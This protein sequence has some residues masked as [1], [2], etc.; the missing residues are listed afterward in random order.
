MWFGG[1]G[2]VAG[3]FPLDAGSR[4]DDLRC[5]KTNLLGIDRRHGGAWDLP[6]CAAALTMMI[7]ATTVVGL[8]IAPRW[9]TTPVALL[10]IAPVLA[11]AIRF[12]F[13]P[14]LVAAVASPLVYN[15]YFTEPYH[16]FLIHSPADIVSVAMLF[17]VALVVSRLAGSAREQAR[18]AQAHAARNATIAGFARQL[19]SCTSE[20]EIADVTARE[21]AR[22][23]ACNATLIA[24]APEPRLLAGA[25]AAIELTPTDRAVAALV[26]EKGKRAGRGVDRAVPT[27]WQFHP[28]K[29]GE[30][31][32]AAAGLARDDG[33]AAVPRVQLP[34]LDNLL[35]QTA[36]AL[37]RGRLEAEAREFD[38]T[39]ERDKVRSTL[40]SSIG[41][42]LGPRLEAIADSVAELRRGGAEEKEA[43][44]VIRSETA[45]L[46]RYL[47]NLLELDPDSD[48]RP[49]E[50]DGVSI[51]LFRRSVSRDGE[52]IH[53]TPKEYAVLAELAKHPGRV[54]THAHLLRNAW[55]PAQEGQIDY[56]R[57]AVRGLRQKLEHNP[58]D[59]R[60]IVNEPAI[61]YRLKVRESAASNVQ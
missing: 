44:S 10:Y 9:G 51:D 1:P 34:L 2:G 46:D 25:P 60:L 18:L 35:D 5:V 14:A 23:F 3:L 32:L 11:A 55:G 41:Q 13:W 43:L 33:T 8:L 40:L 30:A 47:A 42:D 56:L 39:R 53:L 36:L 21:L 31:V 17:V 38:R 54:L 15:Y 61:G 16:T 4:E 50:V 19:L 57:V 22:I 59:P 58:S 37:E 20:R 52:E 29:A 6:A 12:G 49:L 28:V 45:R 24:A 7:V 48:R 27:E 26:L